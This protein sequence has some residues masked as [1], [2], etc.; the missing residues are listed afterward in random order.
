[1]TNTQRRPTREEIERRA[2]EVWLARGGD[3]GNELDDW[4]EAERQL[5]G[6]AQDDVSLA[7]ISETDRGTPQTKSTRR[8]RP[9]VTGD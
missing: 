4:L 9:K 7:K 6:A 1:M 5:S 2:Y 8:K 3:S